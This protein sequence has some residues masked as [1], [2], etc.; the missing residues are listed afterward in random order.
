[1]NNISKELVNKE[2]V[3]LTKTGNFVKGTLDSREENQIKLTSAYFQSKGNL[4]KGNCS[5]LYLDNEDIE[6]L[7]IKE[8]K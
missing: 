3:I 6:T 5:V 1:M 7:G 2:V 8:E 4:V